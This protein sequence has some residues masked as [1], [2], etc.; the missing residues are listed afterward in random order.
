MSYDI[1]THFHR[2]CV[3]ALGIDGGEV[4]EDVLKCF[5]QKFFSFESAE[6]IFLSISEDIESFRTIDPASCEYSLEQI[7]SVRRGMAAIAAHRIFSEILFHNPQKIYD[8]E[9]LAKYVQKDTNVEIHPHAKIGRRFAIDH[10]HG[11]VIGAT[12]II[13]NNVWLY[14]GVT[15]GATGKQDAHGRRHPKIGSSCYFGNASQVLGPS[16]LGKNVSLAAGSV[17]ADSFL[18]DDVSVF[19]GVKISG[20][21]IPRGTKIFAADPENP[22]RYWVRTQGEKNAQWKEFSKFSECRNPHWKNAEDNEKCLC[23]L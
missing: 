23:V 20:V 6:K 11:T 3:N 1:D 8:L 14:H 19:L 21:C 10:G 22:L 9:V 4:H 7:L 16:I 2:E 13:D 17:I 15:L 5:L 18:D 12:A